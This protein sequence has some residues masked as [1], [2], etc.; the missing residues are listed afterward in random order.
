ML[1]RAGPCDGDATKELHLPAKL[2]KQLVK[3]RK[4]VL[5]GRAPQPAPIGR[6]GLSAI[7]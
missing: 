5:D 6:H 7:P 3:V 4:A 2:E 1:A